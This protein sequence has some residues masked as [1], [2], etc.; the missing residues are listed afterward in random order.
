MDGVHARL[1]MSDLAFLDYLVAKLARQLLELA[2]DPSVRQVAAFV[3][4]LPFRRLVPRDRPA[5]LA[6]AAAYLGSDRLGETL[7]A[8]P[9]LGWIYCGHSHWPGRCQLGNV[10]VVNIGSTYL[11]KRLEILEVPDGA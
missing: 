6:F 1:P 10:E 8:C 5:K 3:H 9:K 4:H 2:E 7:L 11:A